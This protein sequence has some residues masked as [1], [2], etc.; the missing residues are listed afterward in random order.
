MGL[1]PAY[2]ANVIDFIRAAAADGLYVEPTG[3]WLPANYY[4]LVSRDG[5][6]E[7]DR[8][9]T[10]GI[11]ELLL[12]QGLIHAYGRY[13]ADMLAAIK[14]ADPELMSA[15]FC[16]DL[17]N[18]LGFESKDLPF[19]REVGLYTAE[20][21]N[22]VDLTDPASRQRLADAATIRWI[23]GVIAEAKRVA[24]G[25]LFTASVFSPLD[26]FRP[27]Y[28]GVF[29]HDAKW[30]DPRQPFRLSAIQ[31]SRADFLEV[32]LYPHTTDATLD[33]QLTSL[34]F[35]P[36]R[37]TKPVLLAETGAF[38]SEIKEVAQVDSTLRS[39]LHQSCTLRFAGWAYWTWDTDE[40]TDLWN[41]KE[42]DGYLAQRLSPK[43]FDWCDG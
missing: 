7:P 37:D 16:V 10:S 33:D 2:M 19:S 3:Q 13:I 27:G 12:S 8:Q 39:I 5:F 30:G 23:D 15:I 38:K 35:T 6:P 17:W 18:E 31:D 21:G 40:Q 20:D 22:V 42:N 29:Q 43:R 32:H 36:A 28:V 1:N 4:M 24:P 9:N 26:V 41:L 14:A 25:V 34:E 11:N